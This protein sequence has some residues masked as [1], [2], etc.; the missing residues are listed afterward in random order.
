MMGEKLSSQGMGVNVISPV[1]VAL[2]AGRSRGLGNF[3]ATRLTRCARPARLHSGL[4]IVKYC[5]GN[6]NMDMKGK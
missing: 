2:R 3:P 1:R 4:S 6:Y 5:D